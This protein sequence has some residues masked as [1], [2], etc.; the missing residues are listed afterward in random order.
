MLRRARGGYG[1]VALAC[2]IALLVAAPAAGQTAAFTKKALVFDVMVGPNN[3]TPCSIQ[4]DLYSPAGASAA[5]PVPAILATNGFGGSKADNSPTAAFYAQR[6]FAF[7]SYSGLGFGGSGC[8]ITWD[9]PDWDGR[10]GSQLISFLGGSKAARDGT[11][12][13]YIIHDATDHDGVARPDDPRVGMMGGSYA[14]EAQFAVASVDPRLDTIIPDSTWNDLSYSFA[15]NNASSDTPGVF[16]LDWPAVFAESGTTGGAQSSA[17]DQDPSHLGPCPNF[18][19]AMCP[20]VA[21]SAATGYP[22]AETMAF[23]RHASVTSY[24]SKIRIPTFLIQ[25]QSD[26]LFYTNE[27]AATYQSLRAQGTPVR[28]LWKSGGHSGG[29]IPELYMERL[30]LEW[31][32]HFLRGVGSQPPLDFLFLRDWVPYAGKLD[33]T[34]AVGAT[35]AYPATG[36]TSFYLSGV[37]QLTTTLAGV[38]AGTASFA[39]A[40]NQTGTGGSLVGTPEENSPP[41]PDAP[42]T[43]AGYETDALPNDVDVAGIPRIRIKLDAPTFAQSQSQ[44]PGGML[45]LFVKLLDVDPSGSATLIRNRLAAARVADVTKPVEIQLPGMV[46]RFAKGHRIRLVVATSDA[47]SRGNDGAGPVSLVT[48]PA[49]PG[50]LSMPILPGPVRSLPEEENW[51]SAP[52]RPCRT[53]RFVAIHVSRSA[54]VTV[55]GRRVRVSKLRGR[56]IALVDVRGTRGKFVTV[57]ITRRTRSGGL[58]S[59]TR[60]YGTCRRRRAS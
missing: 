41:A 20:A 32:N 16:K 33:A 42:G 3:D 27:A 51:I 56:Y 55:G 57:R 58:M 1:V 6:G 38:K 18:A 50:V 46:H 15:P 39:A 8:K 12:I 23:L 10:A 59:E 2:A 40:P 22:S 31:L 14:G 7:L 43:F 53:R 5:H 44:G 9:D 49:A 30:R 24:V 54:R 25:G 36:D 17:S 11:K 47:T 48:D 13:D 21:E 29:G 28:M 52:S 19:D 60:R 37:D 34:D 35:P 45:V 26:N 4:A